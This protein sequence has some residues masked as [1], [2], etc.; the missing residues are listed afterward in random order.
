MPVRNSINLLINLLSE[1]T[2][3]LISFLIE[4]AASGIALIILGI[5]VITNGAIVCIL[6]PFCILLFKTLIALIKGLF[7]SL[8]IFSHFSILSSSRLC[9]FCLAEFLG[10]LIE[11]AVAPPAEANAVFPAA[12]APIK[13]TSGII[14]LFH[15]IVTVKVVLSGACLISSNNKFTCFMF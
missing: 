10:L 12:I 11:L 15:L 1:I 13:E 3:P 7:S 8:F 4:L 6:L 5:A 14:P 9:L 2:S